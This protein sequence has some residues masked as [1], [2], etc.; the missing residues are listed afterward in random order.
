MRKEMTAAGL[1]ED[2]ASRLNPRDHTQLPPEQ[3]F[4]W[5]GGAK[6]DFL[7]HHLQKSCRLFG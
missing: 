7:E 3:S 2:R 4:Q 6:A 1:A 5:E